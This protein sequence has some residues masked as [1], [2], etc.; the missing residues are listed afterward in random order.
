MKVGNFGLVNINDLVLLLVLVLNF[1]FLYIPEVP[2]PIF[3][4]VS[5]LNLLDSMNLS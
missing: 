2:K 5:K 4:A 3:V 1:S